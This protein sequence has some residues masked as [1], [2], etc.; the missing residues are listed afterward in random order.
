MLTNVISRWFGRKYLS[1]PRNKKPM[2]RIEETKIKLSM[3][4]Q[5]ELSVK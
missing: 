3:Q 1:A 5:I 4:L 2:K